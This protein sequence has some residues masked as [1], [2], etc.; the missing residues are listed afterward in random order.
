MMCWEQGENWID[1]RQWAAL[2]GRDCSTRPKLPDSR[3]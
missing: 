3:L 2:M 1:V